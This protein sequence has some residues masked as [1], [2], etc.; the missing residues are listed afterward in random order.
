MEKQIRTVLGPTAPHEMGITDAHN[1]IWISPPEEL[2]EKVP[3]LNQEDLIK[4]ELDVFKELGGGGQIDCQPGFAGRDGN[5]LRAFSTNSGVH[6]VSV[7][8]FH[9]P[10]YYAENSPI[11]QMSTVQAYEFF[12]SEIKEGLIETRDCPN[13]VYPGLIKIA[14]QHNLDS[15]A[16]NLIEA[17]IQASQE[18]GFS[19]TMHTE[20]GQNIE[21][22]IS[23]F[24]RFALVPEKVI[25]CHIDKRP[26]FG[27]HRELA[28]EGYLLEYDTFFRPKYMPEETVWPLLTSM[29]HAG[30]SH[31]LALATDMAEGAMWAKIGGGPGISSLIQIIKPKLV[32]M[33]QDSKIISA[34]IGGNISQRI[35]LQIME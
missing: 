19:I 30:L 7:T 28:Q 24:D 22:F 9:L 23:L 15:S 27:L 1:H 29:V 10:I 11:W 18:S 21:E 13:P 31:S 6:I 2:V 14:V 25:I 5:K 34:L 33:Q 8:G 16:Q 20:K 32:N 12:I 35:A 4:A 17:A 3:V 26:D